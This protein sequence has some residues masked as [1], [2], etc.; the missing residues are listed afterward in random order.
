MSETADVLSNLCVAIMTKFNALVDDE[1][2]SFWTAVNGRLF[3]GQ[4]SIEA[5][6]PYATFSIIS[7]PIERTFSEE[8]TD[9]LVQFD[10]YSIVHAS[11]T[12]DMRYKCKA[13]FDEQSLSITGSSLL[14]MREI[15]AI[16]GDD[17]ESVA[18]T[19]QGTQNV[20]SYSADYEAKTSLD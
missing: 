11:E 7:A 1:H 17:P 19:S 16:G 6:Y 2:N 18:S 5:E 9:T 12:R 15:N 10:F 20:W 13:L 14:W 3:N 8:F 4:P